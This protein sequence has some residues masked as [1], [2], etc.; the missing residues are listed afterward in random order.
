M[1]ALF[2]GNPPAGMRLANI[3]HGIGI[4]ICEIT[5]LT[6]LIDG[7]S[8]DE[9]AVDTTDPTKEYLGDGVYATFDGFGINL[10]TENG[11]TVKDRIYVEPSVLTALT[12]Y[13]TRALKRM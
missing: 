10:T 2:K 5:K 11:V 13:Y 6:N 9:E 7:N 3:K 8:S 1:N 12:D 4:E